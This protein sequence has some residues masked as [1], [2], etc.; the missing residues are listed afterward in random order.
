MTSSLT[1][2][3]HTS[4]TTTA[5]IAYSLQHFCGAAMSLRGVTR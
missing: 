5:A 2:P 3:A 4:K 1:P